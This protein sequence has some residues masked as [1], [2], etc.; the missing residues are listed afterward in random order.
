MNA[1]SGAEFDRWKQCFAVWVRDDAPDP[2]GLYRAVLSDFKEKLKASPENLT[3]FFTVEGGSVLEGELSRLEVLKSDG[4]RALTLTWNGRNHIASGA[5]EQGGLTAFGREVIAE[6]NRLSIACD[7]SHL[8]E[9]SFW[10]AVSLAEHPIATHSNCSAVFA[11]R[12]N[13]D[14]H[15]LRAIAARGGV[16]GLCCYPPFLGGAVFEGLWANISHLLSLGLE[17]YIAFGSDFDG[18]EMSPELNSPQKLPDFAAFLAQKGLPER[19][20]GKI[21]YRNAEKFFVCL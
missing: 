18:G 1:G 20:A 12:R 2:Y 3:P 21:F 15:Q 16:I 9:E 5:A 6:M 13:L 4:I 10:Q 17:D 14:D 11:H 19:V 8:N 7:L